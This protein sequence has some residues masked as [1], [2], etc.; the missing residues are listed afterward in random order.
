VAEAP[1]LVDRKGVRERE[2]RRFLIAAGLLAFAATLIL[3]LV[4]AHAGRW[5]EYVA[6][7]PVVSQ[8]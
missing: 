5:K 1:A 4:Q 6:N 2:M 7:V 3:S 8:D